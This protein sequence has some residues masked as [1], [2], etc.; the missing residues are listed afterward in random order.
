MGIGEFSN[1]ATWSFPPFVLLHLSHL[2]LCN[3]LHLVKCAIF[4]ACCHVFSHMGMCSIQ[5]G[6]SF[7]FQCCFPFL[8]SCLSNL[9]P[10]QLFPCHVVTWQENIFLFTLFIMS[11]SFTSSAIFETYLVSTFVDTFPSPESR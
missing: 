9:D 11:Q 3:L 10:F 8:F 7:L 6:F 5:V 2:F 4:E 1:N